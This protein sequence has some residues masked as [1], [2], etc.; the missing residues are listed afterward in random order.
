MDPQQRH[1]NQPEQRRLRLP[2]GKSIDVTVFGEGAP[3]ETGRPD[4]PASEL[5][6]CRTCESELVHP[7]DWEEVGRDRWRLELRCPNCHWRGIGTYDRMPVED[8]DEELERGME[9]IVRD[10]RRL[11]HANMEDE[12]ERFTQALKQDLILPEDF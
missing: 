5:H 9:G 3:A 1:T 7:T 12:V 2:S 6:V 10:L 8:L 11:T 4:A